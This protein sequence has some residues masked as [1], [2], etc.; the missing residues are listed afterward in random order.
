MLYP[1][2]K[3]NKSI[4]RKIW[5]TQRNIEVEENK[6]LRKEEQKEKIKKNNLI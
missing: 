3:V 1:W 6:A 4:N 5:V 2:L